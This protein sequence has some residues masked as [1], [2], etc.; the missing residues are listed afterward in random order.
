MCKI[1]FEKKIDNEIK[2]CIGTG[3]FCKLNI[4]SIPFN[5]ALFTNNHVLD[6]KNINIG[7]EIIFDYNNDP[8]YKKLEITPKRK[9]FTDEEL[10]Y[11]CIEITE[12]DN[13]FK[14]I[15]DHLFKID[16]TILEGE[17]NCYTNKD[18]FILQYRK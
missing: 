15:K 18:I 9:T 8:I 5:Y 2:K 12:N 10:D 6:R 11:T 16:Q 17:T 7:K 13:I 3:F 14:S 4:Q 1:H